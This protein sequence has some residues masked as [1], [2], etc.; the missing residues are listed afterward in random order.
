MLSYLLQLVP[1]FENITIPLDYFPDD[2]TYV[3]SDKEIDDVEYFG[4][5]DCLCWC[6]YVLHY[7]KCSTI[8]KR[9]SQQDS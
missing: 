2:D 3:Y 6:G 9:K 4:D 1:H 5:S 7:G 8:Y